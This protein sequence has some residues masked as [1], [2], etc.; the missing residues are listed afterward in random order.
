MLKRNKE[1]VRLTQKS[2]VRKV[3]LRTRVC[4]HIQSMTINRG[5]I[6]DITAVSKDDIRYSPVVTVVNCLVLVCVVGILKKLALGVSRNLKLRLD[7][8]P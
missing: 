1:L 8:Q 3:I 4:Y 7:H 6:A 2:V 5:Y